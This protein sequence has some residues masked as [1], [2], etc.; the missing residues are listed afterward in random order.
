MEDNNQVDLRRLWR[1]LYEIAHIKCVIQCLEHSKCSINVG[2]FV[3]IILFLKFIWLHWVL[4]A[5]GI[6]VTLCSVQFSH[7]VMSDSL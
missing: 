4:V 6:F 5:R 7:S 2:V 1:G 3:T